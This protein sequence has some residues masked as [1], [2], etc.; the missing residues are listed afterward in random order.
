S[1]FALWRMAYERELRVAEAAFVT[2]TEEVAELIRQQLVNYELVGGGGTS[3][4]AS[5]ERPT[6]QQWYGYVEGM[7]LSRR[8]P[9]MVGLGFA[10]Y[11]RGSRV[12]D[13]Q[14]EWSNAG[15]GTLN[16]R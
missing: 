15:W 2:R 11:L 14:E 8:F 4:F 1:V 9:G 10:G 3:L 16:V 13:L 5:V 7:E 6:P 12:G